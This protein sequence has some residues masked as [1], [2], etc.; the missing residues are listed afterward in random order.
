MA[1][2]T[3]EY[4]Y[5]ST[6]AVDPTGTSADVV[7]SDNSEVAQGGL[8]RKYVM[9]AIFAS[10]FEVWVTANPTVGPPSGHTVTDQTVIAIV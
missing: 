4:N 5:D 9:R 10:A 8:D 3:A 2:H 7:L 1:D 6:Y